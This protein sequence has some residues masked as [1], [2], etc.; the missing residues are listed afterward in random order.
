MQKQHYRLSEKRK[1]R[2]NDMRERRE[3]KKKALLLLDSSISGPCVGQRKESLD[4]NAV[5]CVLIVTVVRFACRLERPLGDGRVE[6]YWIRPI[7]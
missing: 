2:N 3:L 4:D 5:G 1:P 6:R 7:L